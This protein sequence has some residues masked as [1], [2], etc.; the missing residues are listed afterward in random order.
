LEPPMRLARL[1]L[2]ALLAPTAL[3]LGAGDA[4]AQDG[5][6]LPIAANNGARDAAVADARTKPAIYITY[7]LY[8]TDLIVPRAVLLA[9]AG[10]ISKAVTDSTDAPWILIGWGDGKFGRHSKI[11]VL[12]LL[13]GA[14]ALLL[15]SD[16]SVLRI[17]GLADPTTPVDDFDAV[18]EIN[19]S[20]TGMDRMTGRLDRSLRVSSDGGPLPTHIATAS[21]ER[22]FDSREIYFALHQCNHWVGQVLRAGGVRTIP[23][24]DVLPLFLLVDLRLHGQAGRLLPRVQVPP[25]PRADS[26]RTNGVAQ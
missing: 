16:H 5:P 6:A 24:V 4:V 2:A 1:A 9:E 26:Q 3:W 8:H 23:A 25:A 18:R 15:P 12:R 10:P 19:I 13:N 11:M 17:V 21:G 7:N 14:W 22:F 20:A